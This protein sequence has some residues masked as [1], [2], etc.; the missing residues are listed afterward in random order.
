M[1]IQ[2]MKNE[3]NEYNRKRKCLKKFDYNKII[4]N[5]QFNE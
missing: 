5:Q 3:R 2:M 4:E 1:Q